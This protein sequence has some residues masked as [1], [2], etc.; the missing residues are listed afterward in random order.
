MMDSAEEKKLLSN[1]ELDLSRIEKEL[2]G[3]HETEIALQARQER[4]SGWKMKFA[5]AI[6]AVLVIALAAAL[7]MMRGG[8]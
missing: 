7:I 8:G 6:L 2:K 3:I 5:V 1:I 4:E